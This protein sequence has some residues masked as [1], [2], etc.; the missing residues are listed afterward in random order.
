MRRFVAVSLA[1]VAVFFALA[2]AGIWA[3]TRPAPPGAEVRPVPP[4]L[5]EAPPLVPGGPVDLGRAPLGGVSLPPFEVVKDPPPPPP[6]PGSWE[7]VPIVAPRRGAA[8]LD[9][10]ALQPRLSECFLP[11]V[12]ARS[13]GRVVAVKDAAPLQDEAATVLVLEV[14]VVR[15]V[16]RVVDAPVESRGTATDGT[17]ACAQAVL[18][19]QS[20]PAAGL[21]PGRHRVRFA[22]SE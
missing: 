15:G 6:P 16:L 13:G 10:E 5:A 12:A 22:L 8:G 19:G 9:V 20:A 11:A 7:A 2:A 14:E 21:A 1:A 18:R 3:A 17:I 4:P